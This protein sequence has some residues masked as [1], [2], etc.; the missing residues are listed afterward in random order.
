MLATAAGRYVCKRAW[1]REKK[2]PIYAQK[3]KLKLDS[4]VSVRQGTKAFSSGIRMTKK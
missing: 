3:R 1:K 2:A 4:A